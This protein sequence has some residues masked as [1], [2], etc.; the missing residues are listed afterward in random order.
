[1][2]E[3]VDDRHTGTASGLNSAVA[4]TGGLIATAL[5]GAVIAN[6]AAHLL[7]AFHIA[8]IAGAAAAFASGVAAFVTL[9]SIRQADSRS[10]G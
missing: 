6:E 2:L 9:D 3:S 8:A 1:V 4:R 7:P 10:A 5:S